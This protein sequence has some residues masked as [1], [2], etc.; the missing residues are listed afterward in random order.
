MIKFLGC[1]SFLCGVLIVGTHILTLDRIRANQDEILR[2]SLA[3]LLPGM[4]R[5]IVYTVAPSGDIAVLHAEPAGAKRIFAGFDANNRL[6]GLVLEASE[7]GYADVISAMYAYSPETKLITG[8]TVVEMRETPGLGNKI[9]ADPDFLQN[10]K[11]LDTTHPIKAVKHG[12]KQNPWEIDGISGAT[13]SSRAVGRM[14]AASIQ[15]MAP[16]IDRHKARLESG[17]E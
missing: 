4:Q 3:Q 9:G 2:Q 6:L 16:I 8:F 1:L 17:T 10:F 12:A 7:R 11:A 5:Q 15:E 14:L 13:I